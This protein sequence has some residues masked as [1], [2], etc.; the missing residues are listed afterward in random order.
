MKVAF[1][2]GALNRGGTESLILDVC[3]CHA[4]APFEVVCLYRKEGLYSKEYHQTDAQL[5]KIEKKRSLLRYLLEIRS[6]V[7]N[8]KVDIIHAQ[9]PSNTILC[10]LALAFSKTKIVSTFHGIFESKHAKMQLQFITRHCD[11]VCCVSDYERRYY[12]DIMGLRPATSFCTVYNGVNFDKI[13]EHTRC[14]NN[15]YSPITTDSH[16]QVHLCTVGNFVPGRSPWIIAKALR[17]LYDK[18]TH[19]FDFSFI[20]RRMDSQGWRYDQCVEICNGMDNVHFLGARDDVPTLLSQMDGFVYST[21]SD[22]FGI[23]V[24]EA[25]AAGLPVIV[26]DW[27]V[28]KEVAPEARFYRTD[29]VTDCANRIERFI[30]EKSKGIENEGMGNSI[31]VRRKYSIIQHINR[32]NDVYQSCVN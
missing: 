31:I 22:T 21:E 30:Q 25:M 16:I 6:F 17:V 2:L 15:P 24:I 26:N 3:R 32:L 28:M 20:G 13:V 18:G 29:D 19:N 8:E 12:T 4:K 27:E 23:A 11:K 9:T 10:I 1:F 14:E 5:V 7:K